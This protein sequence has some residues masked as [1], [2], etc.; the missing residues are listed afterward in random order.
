MLSTKSL[1]VDIYLQLIVDFYLPYID[2]MQEE[3]YLYLY[4]LKPNTTSYP[5]K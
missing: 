4:I 1:I 3:E 2:Q 5:I